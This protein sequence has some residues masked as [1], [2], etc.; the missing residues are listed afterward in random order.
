MLRR[1][2]QNCLDFANRIDESRCFET[3]P[4]RDRNARVEENRERES[5]LYP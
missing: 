1:C 2:K 3:G 4:R 5:M